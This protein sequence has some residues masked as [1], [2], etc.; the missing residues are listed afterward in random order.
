MKISQRGEEILE[1]LWTA[2]EERGEGPVSL[3]ALTRGEPAIDELEKTGNIH[4]SGDRVGLTEKGKQEGRKVVR[5]HRLAERLFADVLDIK[6]SLVHP[7]S[8]EFEHLLHQG[9]EDNICI[10]L[11]HPTT[12]PHGRPIPPGECCGKAR[13]STGK[14]VAPLSALKAG[15]KGRVAYLRTRNMTTLQKLMSMG[16]LPG[17][18]I[19]VVQTFP[20]YVFALGASQFA[21]DQDLAE[22]LYIRLESGNVE[23]D[24]VPSRSRWLRRK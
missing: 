17:L 6:K 16:V 18:S 20:S 4:L 24:R 23:P 14:V 11:G 22:D 21:V 10:L 19:R 12:C 5:R 3:S 13:E 1:S 8:C 15:Q 7:V 9:I 2:M